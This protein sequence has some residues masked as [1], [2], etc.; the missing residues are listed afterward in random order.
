LRRGRADIEQQAVGADQVG[1]VEVEVV[2]AIVGAE[3]NRPTLVA[4][5]RC[6]DQHQRGIVQPKDAERPGA[7]DSLPA[8]DV[9]RQFPAIGVAVEAAGDRQVL[10]RRIGD[11][12]RGE[13]AQPLALLLKAD[14]FK[15]NLTGASLV[16]ANLTKV[17]LVGADLSGRTSVGQCW[18]KR[19][20][21]V[22]N[23]PVAAF[24]AFPH[25]M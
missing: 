12:R 19:I 17:N 25:G 20:S 5:R 1:L 24:T 16:G 18:L 10:D 6:R 13:R 3:P 4:G 9:E 23:S 11:P 22:R 7:A 14:L 2:R 15:A 8:R 21:K